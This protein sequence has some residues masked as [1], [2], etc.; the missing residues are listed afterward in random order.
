MADEPVVTP[1]SIVNAPPA[2]DPPVTPPAGDPP[3]VPPAGDPPKDPPAEPPKKEEPPAPAAF[4]A[5]K[6]TLPEGMKTDDPLFQKFGGLMT[7]DKLDPQARGQALLDLYTGAVKQARE[8]GTE[9]WNN[10]NKEWQDKT[11]ADPEI[12]GAKFPAAKATIAKAIDTLGPN[13][14]AEVR[15]ALDVT[16][17]GNHPAIVKALHAF[18]SKLTEGQHVTGSPPSPP[19]SVKDA[20]YPNSPDMK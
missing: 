7:D 3:V 9:A 14:A 5:D 19:K 18:A 15:Q 8:A 12:G 10:V 11:M 17:A 6:L 1:P 2:G 13:L 16:G 4:A 20:F